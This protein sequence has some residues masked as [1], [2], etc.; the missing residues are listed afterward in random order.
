MT[1][2]VARRRK[3]EDLAA[4]DGSVPRWSKLRHEVPDQSHLHPVTLVGGDALDLL[5]ER[6]PSSAAG[7]G[8]SQRNSYG[9]GVGHAPGANDVERL[10]GGVVKANV[11]RLRHAAQV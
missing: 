1:A 6:R 7:R 4:N 2:S 9:F 11:E 3:P 5:P 8:L 10:R